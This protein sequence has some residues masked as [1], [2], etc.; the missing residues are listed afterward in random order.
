MLL[1]AKFILYSATG[2][3][4]MS[5]YRRLLCR[6]I[7]SVPPQYRGRGELAPERRNAA[8]EAARNLGGVYGL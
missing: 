7:Q 2:E 8:A 1:Q 3:A 4:R 5:R 6:E